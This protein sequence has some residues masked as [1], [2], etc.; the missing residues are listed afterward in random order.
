MKKRIDLNIKVIA[1]YFLA[2]AVILSVAFAFCFNSDAKKVN[3]T[4]SAT[5][6]LFLPS[7]KL[8]HRALTSPT[9]IYH[10]GTVTAIIEN[11]TTPTLSVIAGGVEK[12]LEFS[13]LTG[14]NLLSDS[15][16]LFTTEARLKKIDLATLSSSTVTAESLGT[17][18][19]DKA[20]SNF[21]LNKNYIV[22]TH[23]NL[24]VF[25]VN[26]G[27]I[28][29]L[30]T[31]LAVSFKSHV[32]IND[33]NQ[34]FFVSE[35]GDL[36][37]AYADALD[38]SSHFLAPVNPTAFVADNEYVYYVL[39]NKIYRI[40]IATKSNEE[41]TA[42]DENYDLGNIVTPSGITL[43]N[44]NLLIADTGLNAV[45]EFRVNGSTLEFTGFAIAKGKTAY[46]RVDS[47][48]YDVE[49]YGDTVAVLDGYKLTVVNVKTVN[50]YDK[51]NFK[52]YLKSGELGSPI[53]FC[54]GE[55]K[56]LSF[57]GTNTFKVLDL[58]TNEFNSITLTE[59]H[60]YDA[61]YQ[62]GYFY[63]Y[64]YTDSNSRVVYKIDQND[65]EYTVVKI[66][67]DDVD[68]K[69]I[70]VDVFGNVYLASDTTVH[71][72]EK[73]NGYQE[74]TVKNDRTGIKKMLTDLG[75][76]LYILDSQGISA[77]NNDEFQ[78]IDLL[79]P[80]LEP[81][82]S[83]AFDFVTSSVYLTY[84]GEEALLISNDLGN[85]SLQEATPTAEYKTVGKSADIDGLKIYKPLDGA[86]V[87]SVTKNQNA[88]D[89]N[90]LI[91]D[92]N[93]YVYVCPITLDN[94]IT[95]VTLYALAGQTET[96]LINALE[97]EEI[98][99]EIKDSEI[100]SAYTTTGVNVYY[101]PIMTMNTDYSL[102]DNQD[103]IRL[104]S[105][106]KFKA[107][108]VFTYLGSEYYYAAVEVDGNVYKGY[109]PT[110]FTVLNLSK[111][112]EFETF[113]YEKVKSTTLYN[114]TDLSE[115]I[116]ELDDGATVKLFEIKDGVA[117]VAVEIDG[118]WTVGHISSKDIKNEPSRAVR[119]ALIIIAVAA[120]LSATTAYFILKKKN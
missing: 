72:Y 54:L 33:N 27:D 114:D 77:L 22:T 108:K 93:E 63:V 84:N 24:S 45:Q 120:C 101:M 48:S 49:K 51:N 32:A 8:E 62:S 94:G 97:T 102:I 82:S 55:N 83:F 42:L 30:P 15:T 80:S 34:I 88:F 57:Y 115:E 68:A 89:F 58:T 53:G 13:Q 6:E 5:A 109:I 75:G 70:N 10:D 92:R 86:N 61:C 11:G 3:A 59:H 85:L 36:R 103:Q 119:N 81:I 50:L 67:E 78:K 71:L 91:K 47:L 16:L 87:Y 98:D 28:E 1:T 111:N 7:S 64:A 116:C 37:Y 2:L 69:I 95:S 46:N 18:F 35:D 31:E 90:G 43:Y 23:Q 19:D 113:T 96:V 65:T 73:A 29:K 117:T 66:L 105:G 107:E 39:N 20:V 110:A 112:F 40:S 106:T 99:L 14:V 104:A 44:G 21:D 25:T 38:G 26:G 79:S 52:N 9:G 12:R 74:K 41:L 17:E 76:T 56:V 100:E 60:V 118:V 4:N